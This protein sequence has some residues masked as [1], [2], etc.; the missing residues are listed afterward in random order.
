MDQGFWPIVLGAGIA[1]ATTVVGGLF[2]EIAKQFIPELESEQKAAILKSIKL[3][4][5]SIQG[6]GLGLLLGFFI[7]GAYFT[8]PVHK[9]ITIAEGPLTGGAPM[10]GA[11]P[12]R[13][14]TGE[15]KFTAGAVPFIL[16]IGLLGGISGYYKELNRD[17][18][19]TKP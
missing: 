6:A 9:L 18:S 3:T 5:R 11:E 1:L 13:V 16:T 14:P 2:V 12:I 10:M 8:I 15:N 4:A 19:A 17:A 7:A